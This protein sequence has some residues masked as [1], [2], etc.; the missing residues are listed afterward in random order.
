MVFYGN[1]LSGSLMLLFA[2]L[3]MLKLQDFTLGITEHIPTYM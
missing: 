1:S 3:V 2:I